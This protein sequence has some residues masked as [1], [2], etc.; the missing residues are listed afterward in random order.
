MCLATELNLEVCC[1][2]QQRFGFCSCITELFYLLKNECCERHVILWD[3]VFLLI[4][5]I[6]MACIEKLCFGVLHLYI[7]MGMSATEEMIMVSL[8]RDH[9]VI[10]NH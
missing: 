2:E 6:V 4:T 5:I 10:L 3:I 7:L 9:N 1:S 8:S